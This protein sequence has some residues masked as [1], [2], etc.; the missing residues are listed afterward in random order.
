MLEMNRN[1]QEV[2]MRREKRL[3]R[4]ECMEVAIRA[5]KFPFEGKR[6]VG[7]GKIAGVNCVERCCTIINICVANVIF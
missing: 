6:T 1:R 5:C 4:K 2:S 3:H 7:A